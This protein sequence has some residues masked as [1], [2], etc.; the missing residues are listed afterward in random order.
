[1]RT[2]VSLSGRWVDEFRWSVGPFN[3]I[4]ESYVT[5]D[6]GVNHRLA[7]QWTIGAN[8]ANAFDEEHWQSFGGDILGRRALGYVLF[9]WE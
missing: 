2:D 6:I 5:A 1:M 4:V 9:S 3:G 7:E 8:V